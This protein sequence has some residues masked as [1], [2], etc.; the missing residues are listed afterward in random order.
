VRL[1]PWADA[2]YG[3]DGPWWSARNGLPEFAGIKLAHDT[4]VCATY[5]DLN[6]IEIAEHGHRLLFDQPGTVGNGY[7]SGFQSLNIALQF[8][9]RRVLLVGFDM[10][11]GGELHW[12]GRND[13]KGARNP[14]P[15][16]FMRWRDAFEG[17]CPE[18]KRRHVEVINASPD[19]A[20]VCFPH[21]SIEDALAHWNL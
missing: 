12:Y 19:S 18:L 13:W 3:C 2:V 7:N 20:L 9:A 16:N 11:G 10:Q 6:K 14:G 21:M 15:P 5:R 1:C 8:G 17:A 4:G